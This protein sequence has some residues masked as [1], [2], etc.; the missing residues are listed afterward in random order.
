MAQNVP[1]NLEAEKTILG[2]VFIDN[3]LMITLSDEISPSDFY[4]RKHQ[5]IFLAMIQLVKKQYDIDFTT[6][7]AELQ[8]TNKLEEVGGLLYLTSLVDTVYTTANIKNYIDILKETA[9][10]RNLIGT[11]NKIIEAGY[12]VEY[13]AA[14]YVDYAERLIFDLSKRKKTEGFSHIQAIAETVAEKMYLNRSQDSVITGLTTGFSNLDE[15]TLGLQKDNLIILAARPAMGKSAFAA[16]I[17][18]NAAKSNPGNVHVALF[19]LEMSKEQNVQRMLAAES[20]VS[21]QKL[22]SGNITSQEFAFFETAKAEI[23]ELGIH[24]CDNAMIT[25]SE[26][27]TRCRKQKMQEGLDLVVVDYLQLINGEQKSRGTNRQE[28]VSNIS[29][30]LKQM[31]RELEIPVVALAQ[32]SREVEKREDKRPI[33]ADLRESGSIEQDADL[34]LFLYRPDYYKRDGGTPSNK[35]ELIVA[36]NRAGA[37]GHELHY[38]FEGEYSRFQVLENSEE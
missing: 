38:L 30:S 27:R 16:N 24:F 13:D 33:M 22:R 3:Q 31:A 11:A 23:S 4:D 17:A 14:D 1:Y 28:E 12:N 2:C 5:V 36:K 20:N 8:L 29:R 26:I 15:L 6:L 7:H 18:V 9:L 21:I 32:L 34:V 10:K 37:S 25:V 19:T 35:A